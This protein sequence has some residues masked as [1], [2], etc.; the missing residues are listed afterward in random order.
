MNFNWIDWII[1][2][3]FGYEAYEGWLAGF[4]SLGA[5]F[6]AFAA[7]LWLAIVYEHAIADFFT[8][9]FGI[10]TPIATILGYVSIVVVAQM[11]IMQL[12]H[13]LIIRIPKK[14]AE[15]KYNNWLGHVV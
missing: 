14:I 1:I 13:T 7:S 9:K 8:Q 6:I 15:S 11:V 10:A 4:V 2:A 5:S 12:L 3:V